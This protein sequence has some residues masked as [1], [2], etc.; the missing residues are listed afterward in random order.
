MAD[1]EIS[2]LK[3]LKSVANLEFGDRGGLDAWQRRAEMMIRNV[4]SPDSKYIH[5]LGQIRFRPRSYPADPGVEHEYWASGRTKALNLIDTMIEELG[6][7][8]RVRSNNAAR[9]SARKPSR[10]GKQI[11]VVHGHDDAMKLA[12][13]RVLERLGLTPIV[14][15]ER[16][17]RGRTII[18]KFTQYARVGF[19][20]ILLS[21]DDVGCEKARAPKGLRPR[22]RQN[23][24][25]ELGFF[26]GKLGRGRVVAL[27]GSNPSCELPSD[28]SG[29]LFVPFDKHGRWQ[30]D[31]VKGTRC[32]RLLS[33]CEPPSVVSNG[34]V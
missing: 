14:L 31:L 22:A 18:E 20:V 19:A 29:V 2:R 27:A 11:F 30:F 12:V 1:A 17:N 9:R 33:R 7:R 32:R 10:F 34:A 5:D 21:P 28:Y 26:L 3:S 13:T 23:V 8:A 24:I 15:H 4:F 6:L 16:P 25:L